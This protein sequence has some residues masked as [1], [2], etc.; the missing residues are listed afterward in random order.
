MPPPVPPRVKLGR[1]MQGRP[2]TSS[3]CSASMVLCASMERGVS[4]PIFFMASRNSSRSSALSMASAVGADHLDAEL[5]Q[6]AHLAQAER[7]VER[8]LAAH[9]GQQR[10][11]A[12]LLDDLGDHFGG[13]RLHVGGVGQVRIGHD[14][15]RVGVDQDDPVALFLERLAGLGAGIVELAGL[16]DDDR[17][18]TDDEDRFDVGAFWHLGL[19]RRGA[20]K[21]ARRRGL[22][23][24]TLWAKAA[25]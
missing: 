25:V 8:R 1:M 17:P 12:L 19:F 10:V 5:F 22:W 11:G 9:G 7:A 4:S 13:D 16:P 20:R 15:R 6:H 21:D 18:R 3:A 24:A 2:I 14:R 23:A